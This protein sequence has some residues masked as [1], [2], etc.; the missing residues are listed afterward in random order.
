[1]GGWAVS[2]KHTLI[3]YFYCTLFVQE[4]E[5]VSVATSKTQAGFVQVVLTDQENG[6]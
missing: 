2:Q 5:G 6:I 1:M 4:Y 3:H